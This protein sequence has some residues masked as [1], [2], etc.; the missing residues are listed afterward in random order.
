MN[1]PPRHQT[2][3]PSSAP[4]GP[5]DPPTAAAPGTALP[6][7][8]DPAQL[9]TRRVFDHTVLHAEGDGTAPALLHP[10]QHVDTEALADVLAR[11]S[12]RRVA[13]LRAAAARRMRGVA[14]V[15]DGL[16]DPG[17]RSAV[18]RS[19]EGLGLLEMHVVRPEESRK[20]HARAVSRGAEKWLRIAYHTTPAEAV[21]SLHEAGYRVLTS[22][23]D[24]AALP[25]SS[26]SFAQPTALVFGNERDGVCQ[27]LHDLAD[28][29]FALPMNGLVESYNISVA[30][31]MTLYYARIMRERALG[32]S[33][34]LSPTEQTE[35]L[36]E[37]LAQ[38]ARWP[39]R[40][41]NKRDA[42]GA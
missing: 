27:E 7:I 9:P 35:L 24:A 8:P 20:R 32:A 33:T 21:R 2:P 4:S 36:E 26:I 41:K 30:A 15:L 42:L 40:A 11:M 17:N 38:S 5:S 13:R 23:L 16:Y 10:D 29:S 31:G 12:P 19:A 6:P 25:L 22:R 34:D 37:Y 39:R 18:Y 28:G 3:A 1:N 14:V